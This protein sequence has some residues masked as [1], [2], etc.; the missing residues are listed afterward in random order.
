MGKGRTVVIVGKPS[1]A[2]LR[3]GNICVYQSQI[4]K[5]TKSDTIVVKAEG[6]LG[7]TVGTKVYTY[8]SF[9]ASLITKT[10]K[11]GDKTVTFKL[12]PYR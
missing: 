12:I 2:N 1:A 5:L 10:K 8:Q 11:E 4:D 3:T 6:A 7:I 9:M